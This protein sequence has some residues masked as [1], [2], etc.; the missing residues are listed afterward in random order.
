MGARFASCPN[1]AVTPGGA[2]IAETFAGNA[3]RAYRPMLLDLFGGLVGCQQWF[4]RL[5]YRI[6]VEPLGFGPAHHHGRHALAEIRIGQSDHGRFGHP[7]EGVDDQLDL[8]RVY[9]VAA[10]DHQILAAPDD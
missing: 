9:V 4:D 5:V 7:V 2:T 8:L 1:S 6:G 3:P 10:R